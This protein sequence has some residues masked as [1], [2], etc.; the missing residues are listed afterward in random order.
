M[1]KTFFSLCMLLALVGL[2]QHVQA[3]AVE[4]NGNMKT[5]TRSVGAF[6]GLSVSGGFEV[7]LTQGATERLQL[8]AEENILPLIESTVQNGVLQIKTKSGIKNAKKLKA[9]VTVKDLKSLNLSGGIKLT[10]TNALNANA[11]KF[12]FSGGIDVKMA[13]NVK[14]LVADVAG[15]ADITLSGRAETVN[16]DLAGAASLKAIDLK[17]DFF[18]IDAAGASSAQVNVAR[19]LNVDA[20]GIVS[21][22]YKGSPKIK[23]SGM[24]KVRPIKS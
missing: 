2:V 9:Y 22:D 6:T 19:E 12:K 10:S 3:Q 21:V 11:M 24:G 7:V 13:L 18:T 5:E 1:K 17:T 16:L 4:G 14:E 8:E 23:H 15:G 20:A